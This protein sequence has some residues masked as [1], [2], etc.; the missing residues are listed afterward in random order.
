MSIA[1]V[2]KES[3]EIKILYNKKRCVVYGRQTW[4]IYREHRPAKNAVFLKIYTDFTKEK[5]LFY[6]RLIQ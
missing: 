5:G 3:N 4:Y 1:R 6:I 2:K